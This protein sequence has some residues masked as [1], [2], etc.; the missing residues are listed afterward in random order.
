MVER[1]LSLF[2]YKQVSN[3]LL[4]NEHV[5]IG[6][7]PILGTIFKTGFSNFKKISW[8]LRNIFPVLFCDRVAQLVVAS[9]WL[10]ILWEL[11]K[12]GYSQFNPDIQ[13]H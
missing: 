5:Y 12:E 4:H 6:S 3:F 7:I 9:D 1:V 13:H 10:D 11:Y 2:S 8:A